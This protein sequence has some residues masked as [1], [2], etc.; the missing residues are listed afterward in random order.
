MTMTP[1]ATNQLVL[2]WLYAFPSD[3]SASKWKRIAYFVFALCV[4]VVNVSGLIAGAS[5]ISKFMSTKLEDALFSLYHTCVSCNAVYQSIAIV[6]LRHK[7]SAIFK[8][9]EKIYHESEIKFVDFNNN[10]SIL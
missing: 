10:H 2:T 8:S 9:L 1:L 6:I 4:F 3:K 7:L 5:F